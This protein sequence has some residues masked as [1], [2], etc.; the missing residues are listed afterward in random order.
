VTASPRATVADALRLGWTV[1]EVRGR[2]WPHGPRPTFTPL[3]AV[4]GDQ[5]LP[6]RSQR[7][8]QASRKESADA[9]VRLA[10]VVGIEGA[11]EMAAGLRDVLPPFNEAGDAALV[12]PGGDDAGEAWRR[13]AAFFRDWDARV[14]DQLGRES[15]PLANAYLLGRG[16]AEC[17]WGLGPA[18][19]W[20]TPEHP[21]GVSL[22]FLMGEDRQRELS[23]MLGR[24]GPDDVHALSASAIAGSLEAWEAVA[25]DQRWSEDGRL[26]VLLYEQVRRW[27]QLLVLRQDPTTLVRPG[28]S[29]PSLRTAVRTLRAFWPQTVLAVVATGLVVGLVPAIVDGHTVV[30]SL[31]ATGGFGALLVAGALT[32]GQSA[33]QRL[34]MRMRQDAYTDLVSLSVTVVPDPPTGSARRMLEKVVRMRRLT[35]STPP[36]YTST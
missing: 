23:R 10:Q 22:R 9:L 4:P 27:Y 15:E 32:K 3:P 19:L 31:I 8:G 17:F 29:L 7:D 12:D 6:L 2:N 5:V 28:A 11:D 24:L 30:S 25:G 16:L 21:T 36:P 26:Q 20:G 35:P 33:A 1:A 13:A 34:V 14:Q 18:R